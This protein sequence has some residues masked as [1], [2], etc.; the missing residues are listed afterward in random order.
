MSFQETLIAYLESRGWYFDKERAE[1]LTWIPEAERIYRAHA[2]TVPQWGEYWA[3]DDPSKKRRYEN[4]PEAV[5][6]QLLREEEPQ[7]HGA[8]FDDPVEEHA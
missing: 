8:F 1:K 3:T 4:L 2:W 5:M 7:T 6:S